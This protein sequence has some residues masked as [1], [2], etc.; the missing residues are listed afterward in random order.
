MTAGAVNTRLSEF[1]LKCGAE[2]SEW[3]LF[4]SS[5]SQLGLNYKKSLFPE[6]NFGL[7]TGGLKQKQVLTVAHSIKPLEMPNP[8]QHLKERRGSWV[9]TCCEQTLE[10]GREKL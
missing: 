6:I 1:F 7:T 10:M 9:G 2:G 8:R 4:P 3:S 5:L